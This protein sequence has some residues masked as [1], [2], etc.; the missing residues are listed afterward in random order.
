MALSSRLKSSP[1]ASAGGG[2]RGCSS[3]ATRCTPSAVTGFRFSMRTRRGSRW[4]TQGGSGTHCSPA[5]PIRDVGRGSPTWAVFYEHNQLPEKYRNGYIVCDYRWK[6][7][8]NDQYITT[9]R[10]VV[11]FLK[12]DGAGWKASMEVLARPKPGAR[13]SEGKPVSFALV[14]VAVGPD[15]SL[16]LTDH[17]QGVWRIFH[18]EPDGARPAGRPAPPMVPQWPPLPADL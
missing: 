9:G 2:R 6:K 4:F 17:N 10:L 13:D 12:R 16:F 1:A 14:D 15:G 7:E 18:R 11:F 3:T 5:A 8:S